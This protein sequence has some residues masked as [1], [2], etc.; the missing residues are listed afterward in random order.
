MRGYAQDCSNPVNLVLM[1]PPG[2]GKGTQAARVAHA[3]GVPTITTGDLPRR[4]AGAATSMGRALKDIIES[5]DLVDDEVMMV[6]HDE[7]IR[8]LGR[9]LVC[10]CCG[11]TAVLPA[12]GQCQCG[13]AYRT[14]SDDNDAVVRERLRVYERATRPLVDFYRKRSTFCAVDGTL[15]PERV[16]AQIELAIDTTRENVSA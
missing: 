13:G 6:P 11:A 12:D 4:T 8:R 2:A 16:A 9:R 14:R 5:G 7:L 15:S 3:R 10:H 1:G